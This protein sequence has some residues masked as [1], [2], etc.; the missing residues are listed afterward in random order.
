MIIINLTDIIAL[1]IG[2]VALLYLLGV[3][4]YATIRDW[5]RNKFHKEKNGVE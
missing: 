2:G 5:I 4:L 3:F 1:C